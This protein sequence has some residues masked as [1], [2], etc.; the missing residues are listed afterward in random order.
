MV[1]AVVAGRWIPSSAG[2]KSSCRFSYCLVMSMNAKSLY[3]MRSTLE[4]TL[5][6]S[7]PAGAGRIVLRTE[8]D[9]ERDVE[10]IAVSDD[11]NTWTFRVRSDQPFVYFKPCLVAA[12]FRW[13]IGSNGML[14]MGEEDRRVCY[15]FF[16]TPPMGRFSPLVTFDSTILGRAH[17]LR[18]YV[19]PGYD[20]NTLATY[21]VVFMQDG[22]NLFFP[23]EAFVGR[24]WEV[25]RTSETLRTMNATEDLIIVGIYS[26]DRFRDYT[27]PG[28]EPY[29]R[30]VAEEI[31]PAVEQRLRVE[32]SRRF[33]SVWGS[34][35]GGVVSFFTVW[36]HPDVFGSAVCMSSTFAHRNN[37]IDRVLEEP[38]R[39][40]GFYLDSG[41]PGDNY[42]VT[43]AMATALISRGWRY[44]H[45][46][47]H[48][49]F[50]HAE[51]NEHAWAM[52]LHL[53]M[54]FLNGAVA[55][56]SRMF[57]PVLKDEIAPVGEHATPTRPRSQ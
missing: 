37:L 6:V 55:R 27:E 36:E 11:G 1:V 26:E 24:D 15:P 20:E 31:V 42:E 12:S 13:A 53:P 32:R 30:S 50:P 41:W 4:R 49:C 18:V 19:P 9:W 5:R 7:Y 35:L 29:A 10:S 43:M 28:Y 23:D 16:T 47:M 46:L 54:Q 51:H 22:Q 34:S 33:R 38:A 21:P 2:M 40:V 14:L 3:S 39:D 48:L 57:A 17:R 8:Q 45:N 25:D 44:G 52:R 56:A